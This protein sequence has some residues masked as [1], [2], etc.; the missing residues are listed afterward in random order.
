MSTLTFLTALFA[1]LAGLLPVA[2]HFERRFPFAKRLTPWLAAT[3]LLVA[4]LNVTVLSVNWARAPQT[5][6][7]VVSG[8]PAAVIDITA[9]VVFALLAGFSALLCR[10]LESTY[11]WLTGSWKWLGTFSLVSLFVIS[12]FLAPRWFGGGDIPPAPRLQEGDQNPSTGSETVIETRERTVTF[13]EVNDHCSGSQGVT[14]PIHAEEGWRIDPTTIRAQSRQSSKSSFGGIRNATADSF[15]IVGRIANNGTCFLGELIRDA[16]GSLSVTTTYVETREVNRLLP[17][18]RTAFFYLVND[19]CDVPRDTLWAVE[20][21]EG[22][23]IDV[24]TI[25][26]TSSAQGENLS[27]Y[28]RVEDDASGFKRA[29]RVVN[30]RSCVSAFG[31]VVA[32]D[33]RGAVAATVTYTEEPET[34][35]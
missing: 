34:Q 4:V 26:D 2:D 12:G 32:R 6:A 8:R 17:R 29:V 28:I 10:R 25:S 19:Y 7:E 20:A 35:E 23:S 30:E 24:T 14:W 18:T 15:Q 9:Y 3:V 27:A 33:T 21:D 16:R 1:I 13:G 11:T 5:V 22:W 31:K